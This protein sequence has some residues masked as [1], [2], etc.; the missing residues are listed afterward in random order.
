MVTLK[1]ALATG[2]RILRDADIETPAADAG[3]LLC[4]AAGCDRAYLYAHAGQQLESAARERYEAYLHQRAGG[5]PVQYI[6]GHCGFLSLDFEVGPE[7]LVP[8]PETELLVETAAGMLAASGRS[9]T[10]LDV[11]TG[12]GCIAVCMAY[13]LKDCRVAAVDVS[14]AALALARRNAARN[15]VS[16]RIEFI[17]CDLFGG[18]SGRRFDAILSNP[19]YIRSGDILKLQREVRDFEPHEAL[20]GGPDGLAFYR[21]IIGESPGHLNRQ[22][23]LAFE[24]GRDQAAAVAELMRRCYTDI[25]IFRDLAGID[26]VVVGKLKQSAAACIQ[27]S[28][29]NPEERHY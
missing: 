13:L 19:P 21:R 2:M 15:G 23:L 9:S 25:G 7:A 4:H 27:S 10:V 6:T 14:G 18:L 12:S 5:M 16:D 11:G 28:N 3:V 20:D 17:N 1:E 24:V 26:R 22:G 29:A 8:R